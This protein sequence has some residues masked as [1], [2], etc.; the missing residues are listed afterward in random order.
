MEKLKGYLGE[1]M[2]RICMVAFRPDPTTFYTALEQASIVG[3]EVVVIY[4]RFKG[5][6]M[7]Y[8]ECPKIPQRDNIKVIEVDYKHTQEQQGDL[9]LKGLK[10]DDIIFRWDTD[11]VLLT[12][13]EEVRKYIL[14]QTGWDSIQVKL[15]DKEGNYE[16]STIMIFN[17]RKGWRNIHGGMLGDR[18]KVPI[19]NPCYTVVKGMDD[20]VFFHL[21]DQGQAYRVQQRMYWDRIHKR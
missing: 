19:T 20:I 15:L 17:Y 13:P 4:G 11:M 16:Q 7:K 21:R 10:A 2:I 6:D 1:W 8:Q 12:S 9:Y 18:F 3:D 5:F 14:E